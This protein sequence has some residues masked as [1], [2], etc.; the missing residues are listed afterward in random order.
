MLELIVDIVQIV[1]V[2]LGAIAVWAGLRGVRDQLF[3]Q[4]FVEYTDRF[5]AVI[6][7]LHATTGTDGLKVRLAQLPPEKRVVVC[8]I[9]RR[10]FDLC[11]QEKY[12]HGRGF[13][14][15]ETWQIWAARMADTMRSPIARDTWAELR[16]EY[17][18]FGGFVAHVDGLL[19]AGVD[20]NDEP[21]EPGASIAA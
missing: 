3:V 19:D 8:G 11:S 4:T 1:S 17:L 13:I 10:Y 20:A 9:M 12:L 16:E 5:G 15:P 6:A 18:C 14:D 21:K 7:E 2:A